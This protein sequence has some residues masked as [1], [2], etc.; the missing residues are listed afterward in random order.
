[1]KFLKF[2]KKLKRSIFKKGQ[3]FYIK[4]IK[5]CFLNNIKRFNFLGKR[6]KFIFQKLNFKEKKPIFVGFVLIS[7]I[8]GLIFVFSQVWAR[9][10]KINPPDERFVVQAFTRVGE[11]TWTVPAGV[12]VVDV[13]VVAGGGGG[14]SH[15]TFSTATG[16]GGG[17]AGGLVFEENFSVTPENIINVSVGAGGSAPATTHGAGNNG[18]NSF[19]DTL[20]AIGGG[21][22]GSRGPYAPKNGGSGGGVPYDYTVGGLGTVG[23]GHNGGSSNS[24]VYGGTGGGGAA[25]E[26]GYS[27][28]YAGTNGGNGLYYGDIFGEQYGD[29]GWFA[30]GG[31]GGGSD[32]NSPSLG[33]A[34]GGGN[35]GVNSDGISALV[36]TG[37]GG[38]GSGDNSWAGGD[39]GSG[40]VLIRYNPPKIQFSSLNKNLMAHYPFDNF[41][42]YTENLAP[43]PFFDDATVGNYY[44]HTN[45]GWGSV[46]RMKIEEVTGPFGN[47]IKAF[48]EELLSYTVYPH[49]EGSQ[50]QISGG[51]TNKINL[52]VGSYYASAYFKA[53]TE[54]STSNL[55]YR[56]GASGNQ[57]SPTGTIGTDWTRYGWQFDVTTAGDHWFRTYFYNVSVGFK[58]YMTGLQVEK[59]SYSTPFVDGVR[60]D[61]AKDNSGYF[62]HAVLDV[63][64]PKWIEEDDSRLGIYEFFKGE[65]R[66][67]R[68]P[69][70]YLGTKTISFWVKVKAGEHT[71]SEAVPFLAYNDGVITGSGDTRQILLCMQDNKFRMHGWGT[72]DPIATSNINDGEWHHLVWHMNHHI[73]DA[74]Q[75]LMDMWVDG[76]KEVTNFNYS[77]GSF[78][79]VADS[80]WWVGYNSRSY[81]PYLR[82]ASILIN[83][84]RFYDRKLTD[85]EVDS[86]YHKGKIGSLVEVSTGSLYKGLVLD[87]PL[88]STYTKSSTPGSEIMADTT[89]YGNDGQNY[90]ATITSDGAEFNGTSDYIGNTDFNI[91]SD[92]IFSISMWIKRT[93]SFSGG[94]YWGLGG[95][96]VWN[97]ICGYTH[98]SNRIAIDLWGRTTYLT[99][100]IYPLNEWVHVVWIKDGVGDFNS[101][102]LQIWVNSEQKGLTQSRYTSGTPSLVNGV[103]FG[104]ISANYNGYRAPGVV[105]NAKIYNRALSEA[106][107]K[108]LYDKGR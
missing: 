59:K 53:T 22:G 64:T 103:S 42:E 95:G 94:G 49:M 4:F 47:T 82:D 35:G 18:E 46:T 74:N 99:D 67:I 100:A 19:F 61:S 54:D 33:G 101:D 73:S 6:K 77:Q 39:G 89:P 105:K 11:H 43:H 48:S 5:P 106:E 45:S 24:N 14:G 55:L 57:G 1:M 15:V 108:S 98:V 37:G 91:G 12:T 51:G 97:G 96:G 87:M 21:G 70:P 17:G 68:L 40:I 25:T 20:T 27:T 52:D 88:T 10:V 36:N 38:G 85:D 2:L 78:P 81:S 104:R 34:G 9:G 8:I 93:A 30:G 66:R 107:V 63:N 26:G 79:P 80:Y 13:L 76:T 29:S 102:K 7:T 69:D 90:G 60:E 58:V 84:I 23:Q 32:G 41:S 83:D 28:G 62:N 50:Y 16:A 75:R 31:G 65:Q 86:L 72:L 92:P 44:D 3:A 56:Q 71:S